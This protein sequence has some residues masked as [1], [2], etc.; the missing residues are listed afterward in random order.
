M[1][2]ELKSAHE[3]LKSA[4]RER[5]ALYGRIPT[6]M[7]MQ[8]MDS[9]RPTFVLARGSYEQ[10]TEPVTAGVPAALAGSAPPN[11]GNRLAL[12]QWIVDPANPLTARVAVN[13]EWQRFFGTGLVKTA[14]DFG[15]QGER[16]SH[17]ELLDWLATEFVRSG[18][19]VK[20]LQRLIVTSA[21]YRQASE[22]RPEYLEA[23]PENRLLARG[24]RFRMTAEMI[25][26][27]ALAVG[28]LLDGRIGG[29]SV[30]PY[31]IAGL[32]TKIATDTEYEQSIGP[33]L[34]RRSLYSFC[35]RTVA[36]PTMSLFDATTREA[37]LVRRSRTNT[38]L[39]ALALMNDVTYVEAARVLAERI[40]RGRDQ[41]VEARI[42]LLIRLALAR[43][44][45]DQKTAVLAAALARHRDHYARN[46]QAAAALIAVGDSTADA[47]ID[48]VELA[49]WTTVATV[50]INLDE[51]VTKE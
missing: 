34:Y 30:R 6:T 44:P 7:V 39:Q 27:R 16:P 37:C 4:E 49:A 36:N 13:R 35:K 8:E 28:G 18:W 38:P 20:A 50:L 32:W 2:P 3:T 15:T 22:V 31:Q 45:D 40:L 43:S 42:R 33:D 1:P 25:R 17:P 46:P 9:P 19:D 23:D 51:F 26:D 5:A 11:G 41:E 47:A 10:P 48:P 24:P 29:E 14:E 12:A 21:T